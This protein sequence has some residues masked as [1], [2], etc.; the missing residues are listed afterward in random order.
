[1]VLSQKEV[2]STR[3]TPTMAPVPRPDGDP[4]LREATW[5]QGEHKQSEVLVLCLEGYGVIVDGGAV[6]LQ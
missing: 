6:A 4:E 5:F 1:M 3:K 2:W